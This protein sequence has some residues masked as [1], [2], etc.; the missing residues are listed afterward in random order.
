MLTDV[1]NT[2]WLF[3]YWFNAFIIYFLISDK[4][5]IHIFNRKQIFKKAKLHKTQQAYV[6]S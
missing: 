3:I 6:D 5:Q 4:V 2:I 1:S